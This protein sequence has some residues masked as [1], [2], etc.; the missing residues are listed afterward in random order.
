MSPPEST[1]SRFAQLTREK[2][3]GA[4]IRYQRA[5]TE[6]KAAAKMDALLARL[7]VSYWDNIPGEFAEHVF[8]IRDM[9]IT[10]ISKDDQVISWVDRCWTMDVLELAPDTVM[11]ERT[12]SADDPLVCV[13]TRLR[14]HHCDHCSAD[15]QYTMGIYKRGKQTPTV[16]SL[17]VVVPCMGCLRISQLA[18]RNEPQQF[19][20][21]LSAPASIMAKTVLH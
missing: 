16:W 21:L 15:G 6:L 14:R 12:P 4:A 2:R 5:M 3:D 18:E 9:N 17:L 1:F 7:F 13:P 19:L 8:L 20:E 11:A 10:S